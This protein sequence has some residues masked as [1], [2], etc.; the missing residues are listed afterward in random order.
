MQYSEKTESVSF[1]EWVLGS[2]SKTSDDSG[3]IYGIA[4]S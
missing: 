3:S 2:G 1:V 4:Q